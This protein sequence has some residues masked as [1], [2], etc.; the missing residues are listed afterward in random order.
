[1]QIYKHYLKIYCLT[2]FSC[3][4]LLAICNWFINPYGIFKSP[5]L[6]G[7]NVTKPE[8]CSHLR[9]VKSITP[10]WIK[11]K[12]IILGAST[13]ETGLDPEHP[14]WK[15]K[16]I[17]NLALSGANL[18][19]VMRYYQHDRAI[20]PP[21]QIVLVLDFFMFNAHLRNRADFD[22]NL[23]SVD[24]NEKKVYGISQTLF[25]TLFSFDALKASY[26]TIISQDQCNTFLSNGQLEWSYRSVYVQ[27][28]GGYHKTFLKAESYFKEIF[29]PN[30]GKYSFESGN[31]KSSFNYLNKIL[32][33]AESDGSS[34]ILVISPSH[35]RLLEAYYLAGLWP[36]FEEWKSKIV[37]LASLHSKNNPIAVWD[38]S[39]FN[40]YTTEEMPSYST[41]EMQW[42]WDDFHYKKPLGD[43]ILNR[44]FNYNAKESS[45]SFGY[46]LYPKNL[47]SNLMKIRKQRR[48][49]ELHHM[50]EIKE[51]K[52]IMTL[53]N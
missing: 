33:D 4:S 2:I 18:Y 34:V 8:M 21:R 6:P 44:I 50:R 15:F 39:D 26:Q 49:W 16:P 43:L 31:G 5:V 23:L 19:E 47:E 1:M 40:I 27:K 42:Y 25:A 12:S 24:Q 17:Y 32:S 13:A 52:K 45:S 10:A 11:P 38:F 29:F 41:S 36:K 22:E 46:L 48:A 3:V 51:L 53:Y 28:Q 20:C 30:S 37:H 14:A 7:I 9:L 35:V